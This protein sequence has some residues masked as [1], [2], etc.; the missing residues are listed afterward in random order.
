[1]PVSVSVCTIVTT[2]HHIHVIVF[3]M[4]VAVAAVQD[5]WCGY[6]LVIVVMDGLTREAQYL[7]VLV[8]DSW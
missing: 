6:N 4:P 8:T 5:V 7:V 1:M 2:I 3:I